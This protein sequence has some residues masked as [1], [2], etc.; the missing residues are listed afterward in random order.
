MR[1]SWLLEERA[2]EDGCAE[3]PAGAWSARLCPRTSPYPS[4][5]QYG[6]DST[7]YILKLVYIPECHQNMS[8]RP[9]ILPISKTGSEITTLNSQDFRL[10]AP[11]LARNKWSLF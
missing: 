5:D 6:R 4:Q 8:M 1:T 10:A 3:G 2:G 9:V 7:E 11:S